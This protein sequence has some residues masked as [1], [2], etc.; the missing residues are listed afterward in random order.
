MRPRYPTVG[1]EEMAVPT[2]TLPTRQTTERGVQRFHEELDDAEANTATA[3]ITFTITT[4][5]YCLSQSRRVHSK[6]KPPSDRSAEPDTEIP[7]E[8]KKPPPPLCCMSAARL[9]AARLALVNANNCLHKQ[10]LALHPAS[11]RLDTVTRELAA[12]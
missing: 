11:S 10:W 12:F 5:A 4:S 6:T 9:I 3:T 8:E 2:Q 7:A 1:Q